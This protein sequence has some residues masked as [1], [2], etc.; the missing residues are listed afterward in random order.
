M[1]PSVFRALV[2]PLAAALAASLAA[3][4]RLGAQNTTRAPL[5]PPPA[6]G[7]SNTPGSPDPFA[8]FQA[9]TTNHI[10]WPGPNQY[11]DASG[12]P[13]P[14]Y[15]Q[16][17]ADYTILATLDTANGGAVSGQVT[18]RYTNNSP[19]TL[20]FVWLQLDQNL[21]RPGSKGSSMFPAD[22]R[23]GVRGFQGGYALSDVAVDG[24]PVA[25]HTDDTMTR[26]D[27]AAPIA[28]RG[29]KS[30]I[31]LRFRFA[32]PEHGSDRL[33]R[34]GRLFE[35]A[36]WYP[37]MAVY[38][39]VR[40]WN[41]DP[42]LGQGEFYLE[43]GDID[44]SVTAPAGY[45]I[46][47][48]GVLQNPQA[49]LTPAQR[50]RLARARTLVAQPGRPETVAQVITEAEADA[51]GRTPAPGTKTWRFRATNVRDV[52]WAGAPDFRWDATSWNGV[53]CQAYYEF[54][55]AGRA[56]ESGAE[57]TCWTIRTYSTLWFP[58]PY[59]QAT[60]VAGPVGGMEY[61]MF[62]MVHYGSADPASI[63]GTVDHEHG[64]EWFPMVVGSNE[65]RYAWQ[66]EGF[67]TYQNTFS[68][69]RRFPSAPSPLAS[70]MANWRQVVANNTQSPLMTMPDHVEAAA[71]GAIG[72]RKPGAVLLALRNAVVGPETFDRAMREYVRRWAFRHPTPGDFFRTVE[73]VSGQNLSWYWRSFWYTTDVLDIGVEG[74]TTRA[75]GGETVSTVQLRRHSSIP[76]PP[77]MRLR[78]ADGSTRDVRAPVDVWA[79]PATGDRVE[80]SFALPSAVTGVRLWPNGSVPDLNSANDTWGNAPDGDPPGLVTGA[81]MAGAVGAR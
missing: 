27:L 15:W 6:T 3:T 7:V 21:Y 70:Y 48:S 29:G 11:R 13:G 64:H 16:Q 57:Q 58:F 2:A 44:Y 61:P 62:V 33:G 30:T 8:T 38:D 26:L 9:F 40:G 68:L 39:D 37:R 19:D 1:T 31:T 54:P 56:W 23:W 45:V 67:N 66:D 71:L 12:A 75:S 20:R 22:S 24:R 78:L 41:T 72:Y 50:E 69:E 34:D 42:Y 65:R 17:R 53:T 25:P 74:V 79:R 32:V 60:S 51:A 59:P 35:I 73:N 5:T 63:F 80:L 47:G 81:G 49:V 14:A 76:F 28:P 4:P 46:A 43:Y 36:Q 10:D 77:V 55:K 18:I 52:A